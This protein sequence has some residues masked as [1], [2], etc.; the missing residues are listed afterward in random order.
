MAVG[1]HSAIVTGPPGA[2]IH[3]D[4]QG[5]VSVR[6]PWDREG[7]K[8]D[9]S[10]LAVRAMQPNMPGSMVLPRVGWEVW[11]MFEDGD[12]D[13]PYVLGRTYNGKQPPP[14]SLPGNKTMTS[15]ETLSS[16]GAKVK[17]AITFDDAAGRQHM[18]VHAGAH[19][20]TRIAG[21]AVVQTARVETVAIGGN[22][23]RTVGADEKVSVKEALLTEV[24]S[25]TASV[26]TAQT[27][28]VKGN[29]LV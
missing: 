7:P 20:S 10:S 15:L 6:F 1:V 23:S 8:D 13:R 17:N 28:F 22:L 3:T 24:A 16:P 14:V 29:F 19:K 27:I 25:Q 9:K 21:D 12:P 11:V 4:D 2:E 26:G 18:V 5:R